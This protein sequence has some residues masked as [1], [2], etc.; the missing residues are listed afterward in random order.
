MPTC[1]RA[2]C[3][4]GTTD[5]P[6]NTKSDGAALRLDPDGEA[7]IDETVT[8]AQVGVFDD[9]GRGVTVE[10]DRERTI[11]ASAH[12]LRWTYYE[13]ELQ[14][15]RVEVPLEVPRFGETV[16]LSY[17]LVPWDG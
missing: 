2:T 15:G 4:V 10:F 8:T 5:E 1:T 11:H 7:L 3:D 14:V 12:G 9:S 16:T 17:A 6:L 13:E